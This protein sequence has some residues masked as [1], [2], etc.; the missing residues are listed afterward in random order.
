MVSGQLCVVVALPT[1]GIGRA[2]PI[3]YGGVLSPELALRS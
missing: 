1:T 3:D 2:V